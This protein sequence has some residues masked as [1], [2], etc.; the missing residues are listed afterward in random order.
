MVF[1]HEP[2][3]R[4][5]LVSAARLPSADSSACWQLCSSSSTAE[6]TLLHRAASPKTSGC[7]LFS[8]HRITECLRLEETSGSHLVQ[9]P[10]QAESPRDTCLGPRLLSISKN[11]DSTTSLDDL[12]QCSGTLTVQR[13]CR[14]MFRRKVLCFGVPIASGPPQGTTKKTLAPAS[15]CLPVRYLYTL[16]IPLGFHK[17]T[18]Y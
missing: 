3:C 2:P 18:G 9:S 13:T 8:L 6:L 11:R 5:P 7:S 15:L 14:R 12:C 4:A 10:A 1:F 16:K 17:F